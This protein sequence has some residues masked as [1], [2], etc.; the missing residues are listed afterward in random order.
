MQPLY[1]TLLSYP[2]QYATAL[3]NRLWKQCAT[4]YGNGMSY[5][6][7]RNVLHCYAGLA[8]ASRL[9]KWLANSPTIYRTVLG[10]VL[11]M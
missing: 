9:W 3:G 1:A 6:F 5:I 7:I 8:F 11:D 4:A 10:S 2:K